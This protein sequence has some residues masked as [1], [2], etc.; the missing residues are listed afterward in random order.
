MIGGSWVLEGL[1]PSPRLVLM[2]VPQE[3]VG[4]RAVVYSTELP[5]LEDPGTLCPCLAPASTFTWHRYVSYAH[6]L[7]TDG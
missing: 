5:N 3:E 1:F 2:R 7:H 6:R 4:V